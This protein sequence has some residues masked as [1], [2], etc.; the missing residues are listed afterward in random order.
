MFTLHG[1]SASPFVRKVLLALEFKQ[2]P[3]TQLPVTPFA[4]PANW[5]E[6]S[7]LGKIPVLVDGDLVL[8]DSS[9]ICRYLEEAHPAPALYPATPGARALACWYEEFGDTALV[10]AVAPFFA[11]R[12]VRARLLGQPADEARLAAVTANELPKALDY[13]ERVAPAQGF[14]F[15]DALTIADIALASPLLNGEL[16]GCPLDA[17]RYPRMLAWFA[18]V[19]G[20]PLFTA[21]AAIE[22]KELAAMLG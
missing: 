11:E 5:A 10:E 17:A 15:G 7:P 16:G 12:I 13:L 6:L 2:L 9:V 19:R 3:F 14:V 1:A 20:T 4:P 21:R 22:A 18:R 8:P